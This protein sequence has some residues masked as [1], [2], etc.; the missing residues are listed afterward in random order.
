M[1]YVFNFQVMQKLAS[2]HSWSLCNDTSSIEYIKLDEMTI[3]F[4]GIVNS[5][6]KK[7]VD[8]L[9]NDSE[10][11]ELLGKDAVKCAEQMSISSDE[12]QVLF[13]SLHRKHGIPD[14]VC[15]GDVHTNNMLFELDHQKKSTGDL[16]AIIDY[17]VGAF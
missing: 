17:Q 2:L 14:T 15:L 7:L 5:S 11:I 3:E 10:W 9:T 4:E 8:K 12:M 6:H 1:N 16:R 13:E